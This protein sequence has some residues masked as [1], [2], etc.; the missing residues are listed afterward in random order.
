MRTVGIAT[1]N[2]RLSELCRKVATSGEPSIIL[3]HGVPIAELVP[4]RPTQ[5]TSRGILADLA[6]FNATHPRTSAEPDFPKVRRKRAAIHPPPAT[7]PAHVPF[8]SGWSDSN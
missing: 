2:S 7:P 5:S 3:R 8:W 4:P 1:A 6:R